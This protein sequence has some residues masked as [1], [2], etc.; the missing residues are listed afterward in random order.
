MENE[1]SQREPFA[2][3]AFGDANGKLSTTT[4]SAYMGSTKFR[5]GVTELSDAVQWNIGDHR[6]MGPGAGAKVSPVT[7]NKAATIVRIVGPD[8]R[9]PVAEPIIIGRGDAPTATELEGG[10]HLPRLDVLGTV[11]VAPRF[12]E[13][14]KGVVRFHLQAGFVDPTNGGGGAS[15]TVEWADDDDDDDDDAED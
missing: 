6:G 13:N 1:N 5:K 10:V 9:R 2:Y 11:T 8:D 14:D 12:S 15:V 3:F 4:I 7:R